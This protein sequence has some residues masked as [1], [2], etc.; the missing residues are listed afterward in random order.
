MCRNKAYVCSIHGS[1]I[2]QRLKESAIVPDAHRAKAHVEI[3]EADP[4]QTHPCPEHV[5]AV[6]T[7]DAGVGPVAGRRL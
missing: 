4:E 7:T 3:G 6:E 1:T 5:A 2:A